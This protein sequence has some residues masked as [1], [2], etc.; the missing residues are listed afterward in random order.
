[1]TKNNKIMLTLLGISMFMAG[2]HRRTLV[3]HHCS[4]GLELTLN[5]VNTL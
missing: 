5:A 1:M 2:Q 4:I 3:E